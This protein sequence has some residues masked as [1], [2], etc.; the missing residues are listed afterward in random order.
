MDHRFRLEEIKKIN[1]L[2]TMIAR[3]K[4]ISTK[5]HIDEKMYNRE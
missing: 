5:K 2:H 3:L 1:N 4:G